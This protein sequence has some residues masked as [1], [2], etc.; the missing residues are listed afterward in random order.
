MFLRLVDAFDVP[1]LISCKDAVDVLLQYLE[2]TRH[3][4]Q[5]CPKLMTEAGEKLG[6][7]SIRGFRFLAR[8]L[9]SIQRDLQLASA[10]GDARIQRPI[11]RVHALFRSA[12]G[13]R[14]PQEPADRALS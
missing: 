9:L 5:G 2:I 11:E 3:G 10:L 13:T 1:A 12:P 8:G 6:L 14:V 4:M 7:D